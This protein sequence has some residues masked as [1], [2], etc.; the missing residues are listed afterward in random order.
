[1]STAEKA[2]NLELIQ[3]TSKQVELSIGVKLGDNLVKNITVTKPNTGHFRGVSIRK[4]Q[5]LYVEELAV[6]LPRVTSPSIPSQA[7]LTMDFND[8]IELSGKALSFLGEGK[9]QSPTESN[10]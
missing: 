2:Q 5:D 4:L 7:I 1:M 8:F 6:F 3:S 10:Q 9:E